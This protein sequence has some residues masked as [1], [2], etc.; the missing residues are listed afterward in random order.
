MPPDAPDIPALLAAA[1]HAGQGLNALSPASCAL[2]LGLDGLTLGLLNTSGLELVWYDAADTA[3]IAFEDLQYTLGQGPTL[4][5]A[6]TGEP[7]LVPDLHTVPEDRWPALL[8]A[9]RDQPPRAVHAVPLNLGAVRLGAL[10]GHRSTPGPLTRPQMSGLLALAE[11]AT[12]MLTTPQGIHDMGSD[13]P[14]SLHRAVVHQATGALTVLL[15]IPL[16]QAL[17]R[18]RAYAFTHNRPLHDVAHDV[19]HRHADLDNLLP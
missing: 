9:T 8:S 5:A 10:T 3:G 17:I 16:D 13:Q 18:L 4:D 14:L 1:T 15:G 7:V 19:V 12:A 11:G 2:A 6:R